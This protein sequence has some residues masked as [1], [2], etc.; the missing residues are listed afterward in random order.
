MLY[1]QFFIQFFSQKYSS[2]YR[3]PMQTRPQAVSADRGI[4]LITPKVQPNM[5]LALLRRAKI[6]ETVYSV[7]GSPVIT[8][9]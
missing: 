5:P 1:E 9:A 8:S 3:T 2:K 7:T 6:G 4:G